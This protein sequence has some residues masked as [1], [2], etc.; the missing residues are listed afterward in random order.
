MTADTSAQTAAI[1][2]LT[3]RWIDDM[4]VGLNLCPFARRVVVQE[5]IRYVVCAATQAEAVLDTVVDELVYLEQSPRQMVE[6]TL[7][8]HP[9]ALTD[10]VAY[11]DFLQDIEEVLAEME[12][13]GTLQVAS[14]HPQYQ[15]A[16]TAVEDP[17]NYSNRSPYPMLHLLREASIAEV[18]HHEEEL[19]AIPQRNVELLRSLGSRAVLQR[20]RQLAELAHWP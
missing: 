9:Y 7:I 12:L 16:D 3:R 11:N 6:T 20:L 1:I 15:F 19:A 17:A 5:R 18:A 13:G 10:F 4:V 2:D 14:F 8:I